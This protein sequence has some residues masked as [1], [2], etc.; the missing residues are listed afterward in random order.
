[1]RLNPEKCFFGV[2]AGKVLGFMVTQRG[3]EA[4]SDKCEAIL[5][6]RSLT[7][8]KEVQRLN[9][10]LADL[11]RFLPRLAEKAKPLYMLLKG[12]HQF[13]WNSPCEEMF[14]ELK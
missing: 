1:M 9:G 5:N 10:K 12:A 4:N 3:I 11:S 6:M 2:M 8:L 13:E 7:S 14:Q